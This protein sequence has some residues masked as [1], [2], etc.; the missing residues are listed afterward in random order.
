MSF[1]RAAA[2]QRTS[3]K[4]AFVPVIEMDQN[5]IHDTYHSAINLKDIV[6][7]SVTHFK[8]KK[9]EGTVSLAELAFS[10]LGLSSNEGSSPSNTNII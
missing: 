5:L 2:L 9:P 6:K 3:T 7:L 1:Q 10:A 4:D 8:E